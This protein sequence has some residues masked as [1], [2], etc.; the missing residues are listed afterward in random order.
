M[1]KRCGGSETVS[2]RKAGRTQP[3]EGQEAAGARG[4]AAASQRSRL[5]SWMHGLYIG[6]ERSLSDFCFPWFNN[7]DRKLWW[8][9]EEKWVQSSTSLETYKR[10]C[11]RHKRVV[12]AGVTDAGIEGGSSCDLTLREMASG[13]WRKSWNR[14]K[15][16]SEASIQAKGVKM[17]FR[18]QMG[19]V[20]LWPSKGKW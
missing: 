10:T 9:R 4:K 7:R 3:W 20:K 18:G 13:T 1:S 14:R 11:P 2:G 5:S 8:G 15:C 16:S 6:Q 12:I 19:R 17:C